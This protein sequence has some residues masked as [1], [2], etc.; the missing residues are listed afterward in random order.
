[1]AVDKE[2]VPDYIEDI[3]TQH[4]IHR[5]QRISRS[6]AELLERIE[7]HGEDNREELQNIIRNDVR[8]QLF[9][10]VEPVEVKE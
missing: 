8:I 3:G 1:M 4:D 2:I 6:V 9:R 7:Q 5:R 10:L